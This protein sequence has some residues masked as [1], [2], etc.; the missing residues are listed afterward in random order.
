M[1]APP[2]IHKVGPRTGPGARN[3]VMPPRE[4]L[5][6]RPE[7]MDVVFVTRGYFFRRNDD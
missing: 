5:H 3:A 2:S 1:T 7:G 6:E 4:G